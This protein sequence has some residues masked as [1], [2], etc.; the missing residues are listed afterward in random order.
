MVVIYYLIYW[1][2]TTVTGKCSLK[3]LQQIWD[4]SCI[5]FQY[6]HTPGQESIFCTFIEIIAQVIN[7]HVVQI[8]MLWHMSLWGID[9]WSLIDAEGRWECTHTMQCDY[10][11]LLTKDGQSQPLEIFCPKHHVH[12]TRWFHNQMHFYSALFLGQVFQGLRTSHP[13]GLE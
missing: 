4:E 11:T 8:I 6:Y 5:T 9:F 10:F 2:K 12:N 13:T 1:T 3:L 7:L